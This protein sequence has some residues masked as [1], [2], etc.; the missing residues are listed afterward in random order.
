MTEA[1]KPRGRVVV[2]GAT[3]YLG[4]HVVRAL[5]GDGWKV[6]ALA[7]DRGRLA[8]VAE[9]CEAI[10]QGEATQAQSLTGL[11]DGVE[12]VFSS[13]G[14][15]HFRRRPTYEEVDLQA[16][17][18]LLE[19]AERAGVRHFVFVSVVDGDV[20]RKLS[21]VIEAR[22]RVVERLRAS[23]LRSTI[24][25][26]TSFFNDMGDVFAMARRGKVWLIGSGETRVNPIHGADLAEVVATVLASEAPI[27]E[28]PVGG[29]EVFSQR[30]VAEL[31]FRVLGTRPRYGH[32]SP[33]L[34]RLLAG[35]AR[36]VSPNAWALL[37]M[38][39]GFGLHDGVAPL[40]GTRRLEDF[41]RALASST[42]GRA[43]AS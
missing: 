10:F 26:P 43:G 2:A 39:A 23:P 18:N 21:A 30:E 32:L 3:G 29:P 38:F 36:P 11:F 20:H 25:R 24:L 40:F 12:A 27:A 37:R 4:K 16:N 19:A 6:R 9:H 33:G 5:A 31:M 14:I 13:I 35:L 34:L 42:P 17:L 41:F 1:A 7:R 22:E 28:L 15:R 8:E